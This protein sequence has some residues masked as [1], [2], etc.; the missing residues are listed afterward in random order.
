M[1]RGRGEEQPHD[2]SN[3]LQCACDPNEAPRLVAIDP[4]DFLLRRVAD[5]LIDRLSAVTRAFETALDLG[6]HHGL[7]GRA[8]RDQRGIATVVSADAA[9]AMLRHADGL[10]VGT[11]EETLPFRD[12]AF[13][14]VV[15]GLSL[16]HVDD[17]P[18]TLAQVRRILKPDGLLLASLLG[19]ATL[20]ELRE[21][22]LVAETECEGGVGPRVAPFADVRDLG[23]LLQ[24]A[25][26]ALPVVDADTVIVAYQSPLHLMHDLRAMGATSVLAERP[27]RPLSRATLARACAVY[28]ERFSRPDGRVLAT[29]E[30]LTL[31]AWAPDASQPK[32]LRP[33]S[34]TTRLAD[35]LGV[36]ERKAP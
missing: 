15:S 26:F 20:H 7:L 35:V 11:D 25:G 23:G 27:R 4:P 22:F 17:L 21:A 30:I 14:L 28:A 5:D 32:P 1:G 16:Q 2:G 8:L 33:G 36:P 24:R 19:G 29:F 10:R 12:G 13:D 3:E 18:G 31:T 6:C 34:A 9:P